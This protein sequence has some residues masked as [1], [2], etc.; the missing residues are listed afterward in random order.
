MAEPATRTRR[1]VT[2]RRRTVLTRGTSMLRRAPVTLGL[3]AGLWILAAATG[4]VLHGPSRGVAH[5]VSLGIANF[6][7]GHVW[8]L[9]TSGLFAS[10]LSEY[11]LA[12][13]VILAVAVPVENI[14]GSGRFAVSAV[15]TQGVGAAAALALAQIASMV[16][17]S[18]GLELHG[19]LIEDPLPWVIGTLLAATAAMPTLW[20]RRIRMVTVVFLITTALFAGHLQD[21]TRLCAALAGLALGPILFRGRTHTTTLGG[22]I[23][24]QRTLVALVVAAS[25]LGP[26][27]AAFSP[28][29]IGPLSALRE[30]FGQVPYTARELVDVCADPAL[31]GE[32]RKGQQALRLSGFGPVVA[33]LMPAVVLLV[34]AEGLRRGR[35]AAWLLA[36]CGHAALIAAAAASI[37]VRI[38]ERDETRS[39]VYGVHRHGSLYQELAP[40]SALLAV[41]IV[42]LA[43]H[44][45]FDVRAPRGTYRHVLLGTAAAAAVALVVYVAVGSLLTDGFDRD[46]GPVT[47]LRDFPHR[48]VPPVYLQLFEPPVLP[49][50]TP[51]TLLFE[52]AGVSVWIVFAVLM[53]RS[54]MIPVL[55]HSPADEQRVRA[56]LRSPGGDS[57]SWMITWPGNSYWFSDN[58]AHTIAYRVHSGVALTTG[59]PVGDPAT[60]AGAVD[61]FAAYCQRNGWTPCFYSVG[62]DLAVIAREHGWGCVQIAEETVID[63]PDLAFKGKKFQD[64]RTSLN[65]AT[66]QG[67]EARWTTFAE[68]PLSVTSQIVEI[69]EEWV[70][71]KG[72]PEM[73][74]TLGGLDELKDPEV[75]LLVA[76]DGDEHVHGVTS[77]M[78]VFRDGELV[79]L[80]LDFMRRHS[81]GFPP[82][83]E[84]LI[85]SAALSSREDGLEFLS[86]SGAPLA[87]AVDASDGDDRGALDDL[88]DLLGHTLEPVYGFR[89]LLTFKAKFQPRYR[90]I[91]MVFPD[92]TA[93]PGIGIAVG[94]AY[95]PNMSLEQGRQLM[96]RI[97][98]R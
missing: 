77:W 66:K 83:M 26:M 44:R 51:A 27:L 52:W 36:T 8:V 78:P 87:S 75:R 82:A 98:Q 15:A 92:S 72:L 54:F 38:T 65:R 74:F 13:I 17:N 34:G 30:L 76:L 49:L 48:L 9:W 6:S 96:S 31:Q 14:S 16:P 59:A 2:Q 73:G 94:H 32:C 67:I 79:G 33:N 90:P 57:L 84:F 41:L 18:W 28:H 11:L 3:L 37:I 29:A 91:Y 70:A 47:L 46:S 80:T 68:A 22:T 64:V 50:T 24:E 61:S 7:D 69:S 21:L 43:T 5:N 56:L 40:L 89:S 60:R 55:G 35:R 25:V 4:S 85:A 86:L 63:L 53:L 39:L 10:R 45:L 95:L 71:D 1:P 19:H 23:R 97:L 93:L 62:E 20:R 58:G 42:L 81:D 88:L 12:T